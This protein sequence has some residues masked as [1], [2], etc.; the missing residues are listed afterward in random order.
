MGAVTDIILEKY[1][2]LLKEGAVLVDPAN[3]STDPK[4]I[5]MLE[6]GIRESS[7][8]QRL[9]S[10]RLQFVGVNQ[11]LSPFNAG[12]APH[13]DLRPLKPEERNL[14][15]DVLEATWVKQELDDLAVVFASQ[16]LATEHLRET[17]DRLER[18]ADKV[19][20]AVH[21]RLTKEISYWEG[22]YLK[23]S[24]DVKAGKQPR[25]QPENARRRVEE[26]MA[27]L[28]QRK[29]EITAMR[30]VVSMTPNIVGGSLVIPAG[31]LASRTGDSSFSVD[32]AARERIEKIA[33]KAVMDAEK[34]LGHEVI[35]VSEHK[36]GWDITGRPPK[37]EDRLPD[38]RHIEVKGRAKGQTT[39]TV[40]ANEIMYALNQSDKFILAVVIVDGDEFEGPYYIKSPFDSA[41]G[42]GEESRNYGLTQLLS[43]SVAPRETVES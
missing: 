7:G 12:W 28:D 37:S 38:D 32:A 5:F 40:T 24:E 3:D 26:L 34:A 16:F 4:V 9:V 19:H 17:K 29:K 39:I 33:M 25:M 18:Y 27:R 2:D 41:P 43:R 42:F 30:N 21:E 22:R 15:S 36:C 6:H 35:D 13:I 1:R 10:Q 31:L 8:D 23:L 14:I 20:K 11:S